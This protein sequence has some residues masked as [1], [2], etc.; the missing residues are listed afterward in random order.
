MK[1]QKPIRTISF[2][3][4]KEE[5][6]EYSLSLTPQERLK[7]LEKLRKINLGKAASTIISKKIV[8]VV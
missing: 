1:I 5:D 7:R 8:L 4:G 3:Q 2:D 6:L